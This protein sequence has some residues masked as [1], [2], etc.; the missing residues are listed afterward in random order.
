MKLVLGTVMLAVWASASC[1]TQTP[2]PASRAPETGGAVSVYRQATGV[3]ASL[4]GAT[5]DGI[6]FIHVDKIPEFTHPTGQV[7]SLSP[8][9]LP[10]RFDGEV[11]SR[12][13]V[14]KRITF[15]FEVDWD[16]ALPGR[17]IRLH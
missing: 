17:I 8:I 6:V 7:A 1:S 15:D 3:L 9:T 12:L 11:T 10:F 16:A 14:G 2:S 5:G 4:P 13:E